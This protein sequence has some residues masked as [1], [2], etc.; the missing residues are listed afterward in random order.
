MKLV[1]GFVAKRPR[2]FFCAR[3]S[4]TSWSSMRGDTFILAGLGHSN[5]DRG[6]YVSIA[7][8]SGRDASST[9]IKVQNI[10]APFDCRSE[11]ALSRKKKTRD[12]AGGLE[13]HGRR[14]P[15]WPAPFDSRVAAVP[16]WVH[17]FQNQFLFLRGNRR[18]I[19]L[20]S[21]LVFLPRTFFYFF[22]VPRDFFSQPVALRREYISLFGHAQQSVACSRK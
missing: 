4:Q 9:E 2:L 6:V 21:S 19:F 8:K 22:A 3:G 20:Q 16:T 10:L 11:Q 7:K 15:P 17:W 12:K 1:Q 18:R 14:G 13:V 5:V